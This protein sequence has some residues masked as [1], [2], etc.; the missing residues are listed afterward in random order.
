MRLAIARSLLRRAEK[1]GRQSTLARRLIRL[2][3]TNRAMAVR[4]I[5]VH[6]IDNLRYVWE[7]SAPPLEVQTLQFDEDGT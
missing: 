2:E 3:R 4:S 7:P 6:T 1:C 5:V